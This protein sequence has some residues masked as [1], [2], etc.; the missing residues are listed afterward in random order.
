MK[1]ALF[2]MMVSLS[3]AIASSLIAAPQAIVFDWGN[4]IGFSDRSIVVNFM[5]DSFQFSE[6]DFEAANGKKRKAMKAG[7]S[8][9]DFWIEY[10]S[11]NNIQ[12]PDDWSQKYTLVLKKSIGADPNMYLLIDQLKTKGI[13]IGM[14]SNIDDRYTKLIRDFGFYEPFEPCL[15]SCEM[16]LEKPDPKA[17]ELLLKTLNLPAEQIVF[18]D[19]KIENVNAAK[20][21]GIDAILFE[22]EP[23]VKAELVKRQVFEQVIMECTIFK[24]HKVPEAKGVCVIIDVLR[25]FTTAAFAFAAG[26]KEIIFVS[27]PEEA[28]IKHQKDPSLLLM[29]E[30]EG[31]CIEG[32]HFSNSPSE[33]QNSLLTGHRLVQR[34]SSGTQGVV[35]CSHASHLLISSFVV[36]EATV[37]RIQE[38]KPSH[39]SF[40]ATGRTNGDEDVVLAEYLQ[41]KLMKTAF[42]LEHAKS[43]V[44]LSP[45]AQRMMN[46]SISYKN[47]EIDLELALKVDLFDFAMEVFK[48]DGELI[49]KTV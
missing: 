48:I 41:S 5:C 47:A 29:G 3:I 42:D 31:K 32:F 16:G 39:V 19:D 43:R 37:K 20:A 8:D 26:A 17:Y 28:F 34:T 49:G 23:Q 7:K 22:S 1:K 21:M 6:S 9:I 10:A 14:L 46:G 24:G 35:G 27:S 45:A 44:R 4:V 33:M 11:K 15:L 30:L 12:L 13:R 18:I 40:I 25:A 2:S 38:L 36:A